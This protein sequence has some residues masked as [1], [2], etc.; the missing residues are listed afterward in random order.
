MTEFSLGSDTSLNA[1]VD[2]CDSIKQSAS[3]SRNRVFVAETQGGQCGYLATMGVMANMGLMGVPTQTG[4]SIVYTPE[5][6]MNLDTLRQDVK[7][8]KI[9]YGLD[10]KGKSE[11]RMVIRNECASTVYGS[12]SFVRQPLPIVHFG[13]RWGSASRRN[14]I[15][16]A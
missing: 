13:R 9:C 12:S 8:L 1:L 16:S 6:G 11:G 10:A 4:A 15:S 2:A 5:Q 3:A 7:F 14:H